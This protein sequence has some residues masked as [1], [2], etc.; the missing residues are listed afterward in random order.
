MSSA[1][2]NSLTSYFPIWIPFISSS[3]ITAFIRNS[4][5]MLNKCGENVSFLTYKGETLSGFP[6]FVW[7]W[8]T[9]FLFL[10]LSELFIMKGCWIL[11]N[12]FLHLLRWSCGVMS[13]LIFMFKDLHMLNHPCIPGIKPTWSGY[14]ILL[15]CCWIWF[16]SILL[17][18]FVSK[19]IKE[20]GLKFSLSLFFF[21]YCPCPIVGWV[22]C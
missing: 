18:V 21:L 19:F 12:I 15:I 7:C 14:M 11:L 20:I 17:R 4:K 9:F 16:V 1:H 22:E 5:T 2:R 10:V 13:L 6:Y 3:C 8:G